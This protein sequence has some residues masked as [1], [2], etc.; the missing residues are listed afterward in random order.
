MG[1]IAAA[2]GVILLL[3]LFG[4]Q[5]RRLELSEL[6]LARKNVELDTA[7]RQLDA[8]LA[9]LSQGVCFYNDNKKLIVF[10]RR[11][12]DLYDLRPRRSMPGLS[13]T[14]IAELRIAAGSFASQP[15]EEYLASST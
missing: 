5:Y 2:L 9:N 3:R 8:T 4:S 1:S 11:Y 15:I 12:C 13:L 10:N 7:H 14:E 6:S